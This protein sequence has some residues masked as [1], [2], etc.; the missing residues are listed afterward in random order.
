MYRVCVCGRAACLSIYWRL[1]ARNISCAIAPQ[2]QQ[3]QLN[4]MAQSGNCNS[5]RGCHRYGQRQRRRQR[6]T[7]RGWALGGVV[8]AAVAFDAKHVASRYTAVLRSHSLSNSFSLFR[9]LFNCVCE[10]HIKLLSNIKLTA[11]LAVAQS[12]QHWGTHPLSPRS[13]HTPCTVW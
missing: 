7:V 13:T 2:T 3:R 1:T 12:L 6:E 5:P 10:L 11:A 4:E 9:T 8:A